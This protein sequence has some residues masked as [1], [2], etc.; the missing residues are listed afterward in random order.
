MGYFLSNN[1]LSLS[2]S[3]PFVVLGP[4]FS[5]KSVGFYL[6]HHQV[7]MTYFLICGLDLLIFSFAMEFEVGFL[8]ERIRLLVS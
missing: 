8:V 1:L 2:K 7:S 3:V 6:S 4:S 5:I